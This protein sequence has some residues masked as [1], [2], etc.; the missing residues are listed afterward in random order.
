MK[1]IPAVWE[2]IGNIFRTDVDN[3]LPSDIRY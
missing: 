2:N 1:N 3:N